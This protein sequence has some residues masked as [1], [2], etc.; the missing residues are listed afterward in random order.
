MRSTGQTQSFWE[1]FTSGIIETDCGSSSVNWNGIVFAAKQNFPNRNHVRFISNWWAIKMW[2]LRRK[3]GKK[4]STSEIYRSSFKRSLNRF[5][6]WNWRFNWFR[7]NQ[8]LSNPC[9]FLF[10][11]TLIFW[12]QR[13]F[14]CVG[15]LSDF[16]T[17]CVEL[18]AYIQTYRTTSKTDPALPFTSSIKIYVVDAA[19]AIVAVVAVACH[20]NTK[21]LW[22]CVPK[23]YEFCLLII[24]A[25]I[26]MEKERERKWQTDETNK[27]DKKKYKTEICD[28]TSNDSIIRYIWI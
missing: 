16:S 19:A 1:R 8:F 28:T 9:H 11:Y 14:S 27:S 26:N 10:Y 4:T 17:D 24:Y 5:S 23:T 18:C 13:L 21:F 20:T 25:L 2:T 3:D 6:N 22:L 7:I 15:W 12:I